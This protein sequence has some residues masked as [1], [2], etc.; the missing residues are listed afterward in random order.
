VLAQLR[1][2]WSA[3]AEW[4]YL[5]PAQHLPPD[6]I[7]E[8]I[9]E[10]CYHASFTADEH[11]ATR[12]AII[13]CEPEDADVPFRFAKP[14][15]FQ[16]ADLASVAPAAEIDS[17]LIGISVAASADETRIWGFE[18]GQPAAD[19]LV[20]SVPGPGTLHVKRASRNFLTVLTLHGGAVREWSAKAVTPLSVA[21]LFPDAV[22]AVMLSHGQSGG[23]AFDWERTYS[24]WLFG[25]LERIV[26]HGHG[27]TLLV[28]PDIAADDRG[29][30]DLL[31]IKYECNDESMWPKLLEV[32]EQYAVP[33]EHREPR[34]IR[35]AAALERTLDAV[36]RLTRVDGAVVMTD[37]FRVLGFGAEIVAPP[38]AHQ[39]SMETVRVGDRA[40]RIDAYGTRHRSAFRLCA[41]YPRVI[42]F[43][44][45]QDGDIKYVRQ[46]DGHVEL[47]R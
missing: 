34:V 3:A 19:R 17:V 36:A 37:R 23:T 1:R 30:R 33:P 41:A 20:V 5:P 47:V 15:P 28:V 27:G 38:T 26:L 4:P 8:A 29:W 2:A 13:V 18:C 21:R 9:L 25:L 45:S 42:A 46:A 31:R 43:V 11:R 32:G 39:S 44:C 7:L 14:V 35:S 40:E 12:F 6:P 24:D 22:R 10:V 16:V